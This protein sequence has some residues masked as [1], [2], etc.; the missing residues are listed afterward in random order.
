MKLMVFVCFI[1]SIASRYVVLALK[2]YSWFLNIF[3]AYWLD[4][5]LIVFKHL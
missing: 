2:H 1:L 3:L 4:C 5:F